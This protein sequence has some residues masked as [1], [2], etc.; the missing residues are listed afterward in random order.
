MLY[1]VLKNKIF[2]ALILM[3]AISIGLY[4]RNE[5]A[6]A[7][8]AEKVL[9]TAVVDGDTMIGLFPGGRE[10]QIRLLGIDAPEIE[11]ING[12][13]ECFGTESAVN[14][15]EY[16]K[17]SRWVTAEADKTNRDEDDLGRKLRYV[18]VNGKDLGEMQVEQGFA[19]VYPEFPSL[20]KN[21]YYLQQSF[22]KKDNLNMWGCPQSR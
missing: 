4:A 3:F 14:L 18:S 15:M 21:E 22:A 2:I 12:P 7:A 13:E 5:V 17:E 11:R 16:L 10:Y 19:K 1:L 9:I 8:Y 20:R 6:D